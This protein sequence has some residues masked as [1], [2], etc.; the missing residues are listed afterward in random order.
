MKNIHRESSFIFVD[1][2][3]LQLR[4][5]LLCDMTSVTPWAKYYKIS[6]F[7]CR[8]YQKSRL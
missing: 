1:L 3:V 2:I 4:A 5:P 7:I 8:P 6:K